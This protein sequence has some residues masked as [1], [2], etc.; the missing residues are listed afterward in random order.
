MQV[1]ELLSGTVRVDRGVIV[2]AIGEVDLFTAPS[3]RTM[4]EEALAVGVDTVTVDL[5]GVTFMDAQGLTVLVGAARQLQDNGGRL[6]V[7]APPASLRRLFEVTDLTEFL[8]VD[9]A[10][11]APAVARTLALAAAVPLTR[12][13]LDAAL[14]LVVTMTQAVVTGADGASITLPRGGRLGTVAA[15][16][17]VVLEMDT[18]QYD[19]GEGPCLDAATQGER[20]QIGSL[21]T[22]QRWPAFVPRA[23]ARGIRSILSTPLMSQSIALGALNIYS[24]TVDA[25]AEHETEWADMFAAEAAAVVTHAHTS[26]S[27]QD[28]DLQLQQALQSREVIAL[29][30]GIMMGR[31]GG[32]PAEAYLVLRDVSVRT[33]VPL[34]DVCER[35]VAAKRTHHAAR[36]PLPG[37]EH[38]PASA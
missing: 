8:G 9:L 15:S 18:D 38:E 5:A 17:E 35:V 14:K 2:T 12:E 30:Q 19:T 1:P 37:G 20:F 26:P 25:F 13:L 7:R 29:A 24:R 33:G 6:V 4:L 21:D 16:N 36:H 34:L 27:A 10:A 31:T 28:L 11:A 22:E 32:T 23:R 3:F